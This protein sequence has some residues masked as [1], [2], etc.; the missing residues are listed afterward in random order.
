MT[1]SAE[2]LRKRIDDQKKRLERYKKQFAS[3]GIDAS[4]AKILDS[5]MDQIET[6]ENALMD[7]GHFPDEE[8]VSRLEPY[9]HKDFKDAF[10]D[11][12]GEWCQD[13]R[14]A[15]N[16]VRHYFEK[17]EKPD[18]LKVTDIMDAVSLA[19]GPKGAA[20]MGAIKTIGTVVQG[21]YKSSL[22]PQP[23]LSDIHSNWAYAIE[24]YS[25][26]SKYDDEFAAFVQDYKKAEGIPA[27]NDQAVYDLF[28]E[29]CENAH[30]RGFPD[31]KQIQKA[32]LSKI[33]ANLDDTW[34]TDDYA[35]VAECE[36]ME[37]ALVFSPQGGQI[38]D[39]DEK[40][41]NAIRTVWSREPVINLPIPLIFTLR[42]NMG[43]HQATIKRT[44]KKSG[45]TAFKLTDGSNDV[46]DAFMKKKAYNMIKV[47]DLKHD[48]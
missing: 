48:S 41:V 45:S 2:K 7:Q 15:L 23:K 8:V 13:A 3:G 21:I 33:V 24:T 5:V 16:E 39:A 14:I 43:A 40:L 20:A 37:L 31:A 30:K 42:N 12:I 26:R 4:E 28:K 18:G 34:D 44:S 10:A 27:S 47:N 38:D 36:M 32:F 35:G 46:F 6:L 19:L 29:A 1:T 17:E 9:D 22:P 11:S 25:K